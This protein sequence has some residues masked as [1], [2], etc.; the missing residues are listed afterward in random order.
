MGGQRTPN[1]FGESLERVRFLH[2]LPH[3][4]G[5]IVKRLFAR[6]EHPENRYESDKEAASLLNS[7]EYY[8]VKDVDMSQSSC[9]IQLVDDKWYNSVNFEFY[10]KNGEGEMAPHNIYSDPDYSSY[11]RIR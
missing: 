5:V 1:P 8:Q 7:E 6:A 9:R 10:L 2:S 3:Y 11:L 4:K